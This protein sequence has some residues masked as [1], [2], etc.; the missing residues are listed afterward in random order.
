[1]S[2]VRK[3][4]PF[5][6]ATLLLG[7][8][9]GHAATVTAGPEVACDF[10][11]LE[12]ALAGVATDPSASPTVRLVAGVHPLVHATIDRS[13]S[14]EGGY[15]S[16]T[17][18]T[19]STGLRSIL[20][21]ADAGRPITIVGRSSGAPIEVRLA[22]LSLENGFADHGGGLRITLGASVLLE[23]VLVLGNHAQ[24]GGGGIDF[25]G[26]SDASLT[27]LGSGVNG[28]NAATGGGIECRGG[29]LVATA[30]SGVG[31]NRATSLGGGIR[32]SLGCV[33]EL[34]GPVSVS[35]N[36]AGNGGGIH[37]GSGAQALLRG[38]P[39]ATTSVRSNV[40]AAGGN[41]G[42]T[43]GGIVVDGIG[44]FL[45]AID[46][47]I[48][49]NRAVHTDGG[50]GQGGGVRVGNHGR[51]VIRQ[52]DGVRCDGGLSCSILER[53]EARQGAALSVGFRGTGRIFNTEL[54]D[55]LGEFS[56]VDI[57]NLTASALL[58]VEGVY[59]HRN[60]SPSLF[61]AEGASTLELTHVTAANNFDLDQVIKTSRLNDRSPELR[62]RNSVLDD[63]LPV[64][65]NATQTVFSADCL[66][67]ANTS[68]LGGFPLIFADDPRLVDPLAG[69]LRLA[70]NSP[71]IDRCFERAT[72]ALLDADGDTRGFVVTGSGD[73]FDAGA[74]ELG[75]RE[76]FS[77][78][79]ESGT[80][81][82]W[83]LG[84]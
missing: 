63:P 59:L 10:N 70:G 3:F 49:R 47:K 41:A 12:A 18:S 2:R 53:N 37:V 52:S 39:G 28:N 17:A 29:R 44:T 82:A 5:L 1:M 43:G 51:A 76:I 68:G 19:P 6:V 16:C 7:P 21:G 48:E 33:L 71:A 32:A 38:H 67:V 72:Q 22:N 79:F 20:D 11:S 66:F 27:L 78:G 31:G 55:N 73:G 50:G 75:T 64:F 58:V 81:S 8:V 25:D 57:N 13:V 42:G 34:D 26:T 62:L 46:V 36:N 83:G 60:S 24:M 4:S 84:P 74:D 15:A 54:V 40:A 30:T 9:A 69:D 23:N 65:D 56:I 35:L 61:H 80:L 45:E 77:D 14:L